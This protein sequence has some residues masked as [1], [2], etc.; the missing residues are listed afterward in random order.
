MARRYFIFALASMAGLLV[1][2]SPA[3]ATRSPAPRCGGHVRITSFGWQ[4]SDVRPGDSATVAVTAQNCKHRE[5]SASVEW[6]GQYAGIGTGLPDGCPVIDPVSTP[7]T[8]PS[9]DSA[10]AQLGFNILPGCSATGLTETVRLLSNGTVLATASATLTITQ[11]AI[12]TTT[13]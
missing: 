6:I 3:L 7:V 4:P 13:S 12:T 1:M 9:K 8:L 11:T 5:L 10:R 2:M